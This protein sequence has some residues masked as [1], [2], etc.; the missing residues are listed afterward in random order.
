MQEEPKMKR[1]K[2]WYHD[3]QSILGLQQL[4]VSH[5]DLGLRYLILT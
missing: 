5:L 1:K 2:V 3:S 4:H